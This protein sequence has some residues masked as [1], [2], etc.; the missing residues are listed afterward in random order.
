MEEVVPR[1]FRIF[2]VYS[3]KN[4]SN[5]YN[6]CP[7][8][9]DAAMR[10]I[11]LTVLLLACVSAGTV[12]AQSWEEHALV[13]LN[14]KVSVELVDS[15]LSDACAFVQ[16]FTGLTIIID[17]KV[18]KDDP[19][20]NIRV[21]DMDAG[22]FVKWLTQLT[23]TYADIKDQ[24]IFITDKPSEESI[25]SEKTDLALLAA[26]MKAEIDL[27]PQGVALT[28]ADRVK[29]ALKLIEKSEYKPTDFPG[30]E[31]GIGLGDKKQ[32]AFGTP[33]KP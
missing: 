14:K 21:N 12:R 25:E 33:A 32:D 4:T 19:I 8:L 29:I 27:P 3:V 20:V 11:L 26:S 6:A 18:R 24:A 2:E 16:Q 31:F 10:T 7:V 5:L 13:Q 1:V 30:P 22:T 9:G 15:K 28:D 17:P 23:S